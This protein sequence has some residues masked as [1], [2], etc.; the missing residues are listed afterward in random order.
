[1]KSPEPSFASAQNIPVW[2]T[3]NGGVWIP[4]RHGLMDHDRLGLVDVVGADDQGHLA[5]GDEALRP[6]EQGDVIHLDATLGEELL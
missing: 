1:M 5:G 6:A 2:R 3:V 4:A